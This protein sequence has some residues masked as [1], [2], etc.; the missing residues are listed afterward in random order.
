[1]SEKLNFSYY[2]EKVNTKMNVEDIKTMCV[3]TLGTFGDF[4]EKK[5]SSCETDVTT[6]VYW[7]FFAGVVNE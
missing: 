5:L 7:V 2:L 6:S 4:F 3:K 1:M